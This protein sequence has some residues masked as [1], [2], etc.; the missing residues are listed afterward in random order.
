MNYTIRPMLQG[1]YTHLLF[2]L[3]G[4]LTNPKEGIT[5]CVQH[6]LRHFGIIESD[7]EKL[8]PF[9]GP[10][11]L[12]SFMEFYGLSEEQAREAITVY[13]ERFST[14]GLFENSVLEGIPEMLEMLK[15]RGS[16]LAVASSKPEPFV[17]QNL[18]HFGLLS[19]FSVVTGATMDETR[20]EKKDVI[21]ETLRRFGP[22]IDRRKVLMIGDRRHDIEGAKLCRLDSL[23]IYTGFAEPGELEKAGATYVCHSVGEMKEL[24]EKTA[25]AY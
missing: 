7:L 10:P 2:D 6:A 1:R 15:S 12:T 23:G 11:L 4:T 19:Y 25:I 16:V 18:E 20:T 9:I 21:E 13:R 22:G 3:D 5:K 14:V 17:L 8:T 24:L